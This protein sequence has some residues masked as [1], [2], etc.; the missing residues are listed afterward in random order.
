VAAADI[1]LSHPPLPEAP[2][3]PAGSSVLG[4]RRE[5]RGH[6]W[7]WDGAGMALGEEQSRPPLARLGL[8]LDAAL[9]S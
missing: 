6:V 5:M 1:P 3:D 2:G 7:G 9:Q 4:H 8:L